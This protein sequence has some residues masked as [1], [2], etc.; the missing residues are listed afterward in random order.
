MAI[1]SIKSSLKQTSFISAL[2][3]TAFVDARFIESP[4]VLTVLVE[5]V[6]W[7]IRDFFFQHKTSFVIWL[8]EDLTFNIGIV[9]AIS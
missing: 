3:S 1:N 6:V 8:V 2:T 7:L 5:D 9:E 4:M